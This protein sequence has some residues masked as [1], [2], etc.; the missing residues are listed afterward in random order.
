MAEMTARFTEAVRILVGDGTVKQRLVEAYEEFL[1]DIDVAELSPSQRPRFEELG[2][3]LH[4]VPPTGRESAARASVRKMSLADAASCA[5]TIFDLYALQ[6]GQ[7]D[8]AEPLK[9]V[10]DE[11]RRAVPGFV[12]GG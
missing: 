5:K 3:T 1:S 8:R 4:S 11:G 9:I 12:A 6:L 10:R 7:T 2:R